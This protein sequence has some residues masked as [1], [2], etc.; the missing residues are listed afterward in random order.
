L[1][2]LVRPDQLNEFERFIYD[3]Y[4]K[5]R[6]PPFVND[7][8]V[9]SS[10]GKGVWGIDPMLNTTDKRYHI[11]NG[12]TSYGSRYNVIT[13]ICYHQQGYNTVLLF[14]SHSEETRGLAIDSIID[15]SAERATSKDPDSFVC[16]VMTDILILIGNNTVKLGPGA[17]LM[18]PVY[19]ATIKR[20]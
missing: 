7:T 9:E 13:P 18:Q 3:Y 8:T 19:P 5:K 2:P 16:G 17:V 12:S 14:N 10:F 1:A 15:C 4:E 11:T 6:N 20:W